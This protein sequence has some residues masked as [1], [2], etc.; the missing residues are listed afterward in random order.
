MKLALTVFIL[1]LLPICSAEVFKCTGIDG[2]VTFADRPCTQD[3]Q[4]KVV[5][6]KVTQSPHKSKSSSTVKSRAAS[7][8]KHS[9]KA[10]SAEKKAFMASLAGVMARMEDPAWIEL[11]K[12]Q[13]KTQG[14]WLTKTEVLPVGAVTRFLN[15][16][17]TCVEFDLELSREKN[18]YMFMPSRLVALCNMAG[19]PYNDCVD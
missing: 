7:S 18:A 11:A 19:K 4:Q 15:V 13:T 16:Q 2:K 6:V 5:D 14:C 8:T 9:I 17:S 3:Q 10:T 12:Q 1:M